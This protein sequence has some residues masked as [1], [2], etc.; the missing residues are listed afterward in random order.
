M[1]KLITGLLAA[2]LIAGCSSEQNEPATS[3]IPD[4]PEPV[5]EG[6]PGWLDLHNL[7]LHRDM[8][9]V[10][11]AG[12]FVQGRIDENDRFTPTS[13]VQGT[14]IGEAPVN[15]TTR[16]WLELSDQQFHAMQESVSPRE[17]YVN[18]VMA[19]DG[20]YFPDEPYTIVGGPVE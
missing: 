17:P 13:G 14:A 4:T 19:E 20:T 7:N 3:A 16:G 15:G 18:G 5:L 1:M 11:P 8:E 9:A 10:A 6:T 2:L 12:L